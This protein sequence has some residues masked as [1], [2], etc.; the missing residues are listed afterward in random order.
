MNSSPTLKRTLAI[1]GAAAALIALV[2]AA[3]FLFGLNRGAPDAEES[4]VRPACDQLPEA[5]Q[6]RAAWAE[7]PDLT[8]RIAAVKGASEP[9]VLAVC[10]EESSQEGAR[11]IVHIEFDDAQARTQVEDL[12]NEGDGYGAPVELVRKD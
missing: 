8:E 12:L 6:A 5:D 10:E 7:H 9:E 3:F 1:G 11:G 2:V 4:S